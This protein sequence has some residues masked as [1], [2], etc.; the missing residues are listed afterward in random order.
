MKVALSDRNMV[1][2]DVTHLMELSVV[3]S[4]RITDMDCPVINFSFKNLNTIFL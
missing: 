3:A 1:T 2:V 4:A